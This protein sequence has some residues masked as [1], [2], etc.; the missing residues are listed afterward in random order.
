[1]TRLAST[2]DHVKEEV[3]RDASLA[4]SLRKAREERDLARKNAKK[5]G[6]AGDDAACMRVPESLGTSSLFHYFM[7]SRWCWGILVA[8]ASDA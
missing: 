3:E 1:M 5:G 8:S 4:K 2:L 6:K 7:K